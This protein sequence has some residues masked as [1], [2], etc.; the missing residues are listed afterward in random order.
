MVKLTDKLMEILE[1]RKEDFDGEEIKMVVEA[2]AISEGM[3]EKKPD[4][5]NIKKPEQILKEWM[6]D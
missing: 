6:G 4:D 1:L 3:Q 2:I 5:P